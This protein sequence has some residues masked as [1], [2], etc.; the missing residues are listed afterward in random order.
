MW[1][2]P[3][4]GVEVRIDRIPAVTDDGIIV[5]GAP[6]G[7]EAFVREA[8]EAKVKKEL[9]ASQRQATIKLLEKNG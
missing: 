2:Q 7:S 9:S 6:I 4:E 3:G 5:L 8:L 1:K